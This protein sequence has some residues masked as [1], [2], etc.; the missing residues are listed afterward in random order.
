[1]QKALRAI[2][3]DITTLRVDAIVNAANSSLLGGGG[4][5]GAIHR[6]AGP[7]LVHECRLL[8]GCKTG[9]AKLTKGYRLPARFVI[10][11]VGPVWRGGSSGEPGLLASCY[12]KSM[13]LAAQCG[14]R[15]VAFP[16]ISTGIYGYPIELAA[17]IAVATVRSALTEGA[18]VEEVTFCCFSDADLAV[19]QVVLAATGAA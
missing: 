9:D 12:R 7:E 11:T 1:M 3:G 18:S 10:H 4:V 13:E 19:Y 14:A 17:P 16:S 5:D 8:A 15:T 6:A 2:R